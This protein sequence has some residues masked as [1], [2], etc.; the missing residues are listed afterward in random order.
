M[1]E[2]VIQRV[3]GT[4]KTLGIEPEEARS[5]DGQYN[6]S[7]DG[8]TE[9]MIDVW[10]DDDR[11]FFQVMSPLGALKF[12]EPCELYKTLLEENHSLVEAAFTLIEEEVFIRETVECSAFFSQ[13]RAMSVITRIAYYSEAYRGQWRKAE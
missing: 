11:V 8:N 4:L 9:L 2:E 6:I 12:N 5:A 1:F 3:E 10:K 7:K 13:D